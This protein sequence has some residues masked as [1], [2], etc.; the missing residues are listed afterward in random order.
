[1]CEP[2]ASS[3]WSP[4][5]ITGFSALIGSWKII[6]RWA[7][8]SR[9]RSAPRRSSRFRPGRPEY[10]TSPTDHTGG[11]GISPMSVRHVTLLPQPLSPT[12]PRISPARSENETSSTARTTAPSASMYVWRPDTRRISSAATSVTGAKEVG[13]AVADEAEADA[14]EDDGDA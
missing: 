8:R 9:W 3:I 1:S 6:D 12:R 4:T 14:H 5:R 11:D 13:E 2:T 7:P 10:S